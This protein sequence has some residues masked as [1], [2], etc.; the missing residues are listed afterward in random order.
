MRLIRIFGAGEID[1]LAREIIARGY[2]TVVYTDQ[3]GACY[4]A[5]TNYPRGSLAFVGSADHVEAITALVDSLEQV[6]FVV[7]TEIAA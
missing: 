7:A 6:A 2:S 3:G 4:C 5:G 1:T